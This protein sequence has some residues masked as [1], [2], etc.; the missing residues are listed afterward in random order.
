[1]ERLLISLWGICNPFGVWLSLFKISFL[2]DWVL[3]LFWGTSWDC[4]G[5]FPGGLGAF[6]GARLRLG[7]VLGGFGIGFEAFRG[8]GVRGWKVLGDSGA[9]GMRPAAISGES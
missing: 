7:A 3:G 6:C 2:S 1:M 8:K 9:V 5:G 4:P